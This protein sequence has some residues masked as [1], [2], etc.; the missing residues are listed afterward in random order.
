MSIK[1][2]N[3][4]IRALQHHHS[5]WFPLTRTE[6]HQDSPSFACDKVLPVTPTPH[7]ATSARF[8]VTPLSSEVLN[9]PETNPFTDP[10]QHS[11][12]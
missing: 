7:V 6:I 8:V 10:Y 11:T 4:R 9:Y 2:L 1:Q 3:F 12:Q 5:K